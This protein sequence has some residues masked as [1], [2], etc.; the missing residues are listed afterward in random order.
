M[1]RSGHA[2]AVQSRTGLSSTAYLAASLRDASAEVPP[3]YGNWNANNRRSRRW[4]EAGVWEA[5]TVMLDEIMANSGRYIIDSTTL[6]AQ[7]SAAG[8]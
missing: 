6:G 3:K 8:G 5:V 1:R 4:S 7:V 2:V